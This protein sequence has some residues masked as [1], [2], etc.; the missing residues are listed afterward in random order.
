MK[1]HFATSSWGGRR[2]LPYVFTEQG[3]VMF[4]TVLHSDRAI[5][6]N[7]NIMRTFVNLRQF[8]STMKT[9]YES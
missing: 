2:T 6:V 9:S 1:S 3:V 4:S 7:I 5:E 8:L